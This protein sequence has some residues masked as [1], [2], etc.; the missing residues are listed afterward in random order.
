MST[1]HPTHR[2][3]HLHALVVDDD[4]FMLDVVSLTLQRLGVRQVDTAASGEAAL[5]RLSTP[6]TP[7]H[8]LLCDLNMPGMDGIELL[9]HVGNLEFG[10]GVILFSGAD[11]RILKAAVSLARARFLNVLGSLQKPVTLEALGHFLDHFDAAR[12]LRDS[13]PRLST[14]SVHELRQ[15]LEQRHLCLFYQPQVDMRDGR[16]VGVEALARLRHPQYGLLG[17]ATFVP[18][19][20]QDDLIRPFTEAVVREALDQTRLWRRQGLNFRVSVNISA[21]ALSQLDLPHALGALC[22]ERALDPAGILLEITESHLD[23]DIITSL[24]VLTRLRL[25]GFG[26]S[27]DDFGTGYSSL[28]R[29]KRVPFDELKIDGSFVHGASLDQAAHAI[30][31]S[32]VALGQQLSLSVV[33]EGVENIEDWNLCAALGCDVVQGYLVARPMPADDFAAWLSRW[34][35]LDSLPLTPG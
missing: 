13:G 33:A 35:G 27:I 10:G 15:S 29:L 28:D 2:F 25:Q 31:E 12:T 34:R 8:L 14:L 23:Q 3:A 24:E 9:R 26:L 11:E 30:F 18:L 32:S 16:L 21:A 20:E 1:Q 19:S 17:P 7:F 5:A 4:P 22:H 6:E